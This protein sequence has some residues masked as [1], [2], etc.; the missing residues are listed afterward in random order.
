[1][2]AEDVRLLGGQDTPSVWTQ[3]ADLADLPG[4]M[5]IAAH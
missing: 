1:L 2:L 4:V 3:D 5:Y